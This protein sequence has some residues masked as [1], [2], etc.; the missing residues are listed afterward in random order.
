M[1]RTLLNDSLRWTLSFPNFN[2]VPLEDLTAC[3]DP[4]IPGARGIDSL[5]EES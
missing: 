1:R 5:R 3:F 2:L 4:K